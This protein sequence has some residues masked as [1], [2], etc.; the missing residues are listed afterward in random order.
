[1]EGWPYWAGPHHKLLQCLYQVLNFMVNNNGKITLLE[2]V[3]GVPEVV[4]KHLL[5]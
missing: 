2:G 3:Q 1:M 5:P 4:R